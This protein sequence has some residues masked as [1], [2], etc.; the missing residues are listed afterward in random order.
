MKRT[1]AAARRL[2]DRTASAVMRL[3]AFVEA[4]EITVDEFR[5]L[6]AQLVAAANAAGVMLADIGLAAEVMR[7]IG[8]PA[9]PVGLTDPVAVDQ[10]RIGRSLTA[11]IDTPSGEAAA[12]RLERVV[13]SE[14]LL[15]V[16]NAVQAGM[17]A[18]GAIGWTRQLTGTSCSLCTSWADGRVRPPT[19]RMA[20]HL[21]CDCIQAPVFTRN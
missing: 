10:T 8:R 1:Q 6:A 20:R 21:G 19:V 17:I 2:A 16:A 13:R 11:A 15:T 18:H 12:A 7:Q 4:G 14:P 3:W 5:R 9:R